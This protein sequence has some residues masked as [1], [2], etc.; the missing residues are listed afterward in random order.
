MSGAQASQPDSPTAFSRSA[1]DFA[2]RLLSASGD[3][4][5]GLDGVLAELA[6][7]L[8]VPAV[9][10]ASQSGEP[11]A[12]H[13]AEVKSL[14]W[15][16]DRT[17]LDRIGPEPAG[18]S[19]PRFGSGSFLI[20]KI[21]S[22]GGNG[23]LL[24]LEDVQR[25]HWTKDEGAALALVGQAL[26]GR[27]GGGDGPRWAR[28]L[29]R[30][31]QQKR[32]EDAALVARRLAHDYGNVL[33]PILGFSE[34]ALSQGSLSAQLRGYLNELQACSQNGV[35]LTNQ[36]R[37]F[38]RREQVSGGSCRLGGPLLEE[39][40]R[41]WPLLGSR[42]LRLEIPPDL[43]AVGLDHASLRHVLGALLDNAREA[44]TGPG[45]ITLTARMTRLSLADCLDAYGSLQPGDHVEIRI[46]DTGPGL[47]PE[48]AQK[49]FAEPFFTTK[50][51]GRGYGLAVAFGVLRTHRGGLLVRSNAGGG[52][53]AH[54]FL[55]VASVPVS[56]PVPSPFEA[57]PSE[58]VR[59]ERVLV[60]DDD[61]RILKLVCMTLQRAGYQVEAA[62][63]AEEAFARYAGAFPEPFHLVLS[64]VIMPRA[65]GVDLAKR[66]LGRDANVR[67]LFMSG[68]VS[69][70]FTRQDSVAAR[71]DLLPK[72][73]QPEGL[74]RAVRSALDR[75]S[76]H[77]PP[78]PAASGP[79]SLPSKSR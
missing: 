63:D 10:L 17:V 18:L 4:S 41:L 73:F 11:L 59:G 8:S 20:T 13:P 50:P 6:A 23:W 33:T 38:G 55:P 48:A 40:N 79:M 74:L 46:A 49:I 36:L 21:H 77:P 65:T 54:V 12:W 24:W 9:G 64:D 62:A 25:S 16:N 69:P 2:H 47:S 37:L 75:T 32:L 76:P 39:E 78:F 5:I 60:V 14:P 58:P 57:R 68:Q 35:A 43:P 31:A 44:L 72:P 15:E 22:P 66:L 42:V 30:A 70:D 51:R 26:A 34:L 45:T 27:L 19:L 71:F 7:A 52:V 1:L 56:A 29:A 53:T 3:D 67:L 61:P 28:Q